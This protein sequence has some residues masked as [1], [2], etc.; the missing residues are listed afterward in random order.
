MTLHHDGAQACALLGSSLLKA[1]SKVF[2]SPE[3]AWVV[4]LS[5]LY[6]EGFAKHVVI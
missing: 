3:V 5:V 1:A 6:K 2:E 4:S